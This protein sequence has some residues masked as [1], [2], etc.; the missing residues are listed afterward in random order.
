[1]RQVGLNSNLYYSLACMRTLA[2]AACA[3]LVLHVLTVAASQSDPT[4][5]QAVAPARVANNIY[6]VG[7]AGLSAFFIQTNAG[8]ILIDSGEPE[9]VPL[10]RASIEKLGHQMP[11]IKILLAGHA[12]F[13][14][15]GGHAEIKRLSGAKVYVMDADRDALQS[16][17][18]R[19][20]LGAQGW[21]PVGIDHVLK[22]GDTVTLGET[23]LT[24][25][26]TPGHTQGCTT[27]TMATNEDGRSR[28]VAFVCSV[29][30]NE[31]VK[32]V[33]NRRVPAIAQHYEQAF[34]VL[35]GLSPDI[36][37]AEHPSVF[38][39]EVKAAR[40]ERPNAFVDPDGYLKFVEQSERSFRTQ[41]SAEQ[42]R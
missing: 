3:T 27:W 34:R 11:E 26:L 41:L 13:D 33:G 14:H 37:V 16:G 20:A 10:I 6:Y 21:T 22:D 42:K 40:G 5:R 2:S 7:T 12:H 25:H 39:F 23:T 24:A 18:D 30:V 4:W 8:A 29:T 1:M 32:L 36:F 38:G 35:R 15:V 17:V 9:S 28:Q 19:S 31:G